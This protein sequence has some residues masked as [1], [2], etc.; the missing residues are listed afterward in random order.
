MTTTTFRLRKGFR[1]SRK[2]Y[3][4]GVIGIYDNGGKTIDRYTVVFEPHQ[5]EGSPHKS[6]PILGMNN[7]PFSPRGFGQ[8][9]TIL[10]RYTRQAGERTI[11]FAD[12]P[13]DCQKCVFQDLEPSI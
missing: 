1:R 7:A 13:T 12:L 11:N 5:N 8:H 10:F 9:E 2:D 3:P 6:Y 4:Q